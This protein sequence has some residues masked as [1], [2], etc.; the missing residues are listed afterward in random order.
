MLTVKMTSDSSA[1]L[2]F[3][4]H[5]IFFKKSQSKIYGPFVFGLSLNF[6][7]NDVLILNHV[8][9]YILLIILDSSLLYMVIS[10]TSFQ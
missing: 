6:S 7:F 10:F 8:D 3:C 4:F 1:L 9:D 2:F 5:F